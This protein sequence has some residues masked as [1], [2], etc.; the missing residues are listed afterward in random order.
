M[1]LPLYPAPRRML[2]MHGVYSPSLHAILHVAKDVFTPSRA[3]EICDLWRRFA[4]TVGTLTIH[5]DESLPAHTVRMGSADCTVEAGDDYALVVSQDGFAINGCDNTGLLHGVFTLLQLLR[6]ICL[7]VGGEMLAINYT[8]IH[9][10]AAL[11]IRS[12]HVCVFP[13]TTLDILEKTI[14]LAAFTKFTHIVLEFWGTIRLDCFPEL[15]WGDHSFSKEEIRPLVALA[16][17]LGLE[18]IPMIN[19]LGH[20]T[21]SRGGS[22]RHTILDQNPRLSLLF[23]PDGWTWCLSNPKIHALLQDIRA[24]LMELCGDGEYFHIGCDEAYSYA[25]CPLCR[26]LDKP[27]MLADFI[28]QVVKELDLHGRKCI[29]WGDALLDSTEWKHPHIATSRPDQKT[30]LALDKLDRRLIIADWQYYLTTPEIPTA[31]YFMNLGFE[32]LA[33]S[34]D[35]NHNARILAAAADQGNMGGVMVTTWHHLAAMLRNITELGG[36]AWCG[37]D[38]EENPGQRFLTHSATLLRKV[39]PVASCFDKAGFLPLE[40]DPVSTKYI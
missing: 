38:Y 9:D 34:W 32:V 10:R 2:D 6:P 7:D 20:A 22:G 18:V 14:R 33:S 35:E 3:R 21:Q 13:E 15:G 30:H 5:V 8:I 25:S 29:I 11:G 40:I 23:E 24:E 26:D 12:I 31:Q 16:H 36:S 19:H 1:S 37:A 28:N 39:M 17:T 4:C 27:Q